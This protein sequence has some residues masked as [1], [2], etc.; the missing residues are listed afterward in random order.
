M[1]PVDRRPAI[2]IHDLH[3]HFG[4]QQVLRGV[5]LS[6]G[7]A[8]RVVILGRSGTGKSVLLKILVGLQRPDAGSVR[9]NGEDVSTLSRDQ[10]NAVR[11]RIGFVF[12]DAALYDSLSVEENVAFPLR[13][14]SGTSTNDQLRERIHSLLSSV[15]LSEESRKLPAQI[16]GGMKKRVGLARALALEPELLFF[17]EP[18][19]GLDPITATEMTELILSVTRNTHATCVFVTHDL[20]SARAIADR[21]VLLDEGRILIEGTFEDLQHSDVPLVAQYVRQGC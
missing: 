20:R 11:T 18:T 3:K 8:D 12:Q 17:D 2:E 7:R 9:I 21:L 14:H 19:A 15:G 10:L 4:S 1:S 6:V 5:T 13:R 16:S